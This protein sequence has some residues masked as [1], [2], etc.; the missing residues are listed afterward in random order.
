MN[1]SKKKNILFFAFSV[2]SFLLKNKKQNIIIFS[3]INLI[4]SEKSHSS[5]QKQISLFINLFIK[6]LNS[7]ILD[8]NIFF[9][10]K[11]FKTNWIKRYSYGLFLDKIS[12]C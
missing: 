6:I 8:L 2:L 5:S 10:G 12:D 4:N 1:S 3:S 7:E 9:K 11:L